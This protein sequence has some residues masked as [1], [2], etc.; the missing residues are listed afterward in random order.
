MRDEFLES[1]L[2]AQGSP[3]ERPFVQANAR[4]ISESMPPMS[5]Q[6]TK[7]SLPYP[8]PGKGVSGETTN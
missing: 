1:V 3:T 7:G 8:Y 5:Q 6:E 2:T 4:A